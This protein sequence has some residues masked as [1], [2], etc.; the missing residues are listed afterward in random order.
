M[1]TQTVTFVVED[2]WLSMRSGAIPVEDVIVTKIEGKAIKVVYAREG[3]TV[4]G[5]FDVTVTSESE[6]DAQAIHDK[7][8]ADLR[9][10][11]RAVA[12]AQTIGR[13]LA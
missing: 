9:A 6:S 5:S 2:G 12:R 10:H 4:T 7:L 13:V 8:V 1:S 11:S 3:T